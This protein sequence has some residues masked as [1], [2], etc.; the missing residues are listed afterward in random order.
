MH[1]YSIPGA[2]LHG[3]LSKCGGNQF[4]SLFDKRSPRVEMRELVLNVLPLYACTGIMHRYCAPVGSRAL[5]NRT[6]RPSY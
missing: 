1:R 2:F 5:A 6:E 4:P 3:T